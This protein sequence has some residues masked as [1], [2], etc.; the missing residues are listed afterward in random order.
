MLS[1]GGGEKLGPSP[2]ENASN[3][4]YWNDSNEPE[5]LSCAVQECFFFLFF[6][7]VKGNRGFVST[8]FITPRCLVVFYYRAVFSDHQQRVQPSF[9]P[10][11]LPSPLPVKVSPTFSQCFSLLS[12]NPHQQLSSG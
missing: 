9:S 1:E 6:L 10:P 4:V 5:A 12:E 11:V 8:P 3:Y 2:L 7:N